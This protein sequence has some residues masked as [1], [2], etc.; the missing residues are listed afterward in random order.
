[1]MRTQYN[2]DLLLRYPKVNDRMICKV[3]SFVLLR[4][5]GSVCGEILFVHCIV[6]RTSKP[7]V[8]IS[9]ATQVAQSYLGPQRLAFFTSNHDIW[10]CGAYK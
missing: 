10:K 1:M 5:F 8:D 2:D 7:Y 6:R 9:K 4:A 3:I